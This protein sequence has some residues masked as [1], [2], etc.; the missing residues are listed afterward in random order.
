MSARRHEDAHAVGFLRYCLDEARTSLTRR[1]RVALLSTL[2][3]AAAVFVVAAALGVSTA[4]RDVSARMTQAAELSVYLAREATMAERDAAAQMT[5]A[6]T[7]VAGA[8]VLDPDQATARVTADFPDLAGVIT[9]L[10]EKPF[11]AVIEVRLAPTATETQ[12]EA[13]VARLRGASGVD[14]V[15]YDREVL[16]RVLLTVTTVRRVVTLL[17]TLLA[18]AAFAAVAAVL[19]LGYYA[20]RDEIDV[21]GLVGAPPRAISG[22]FIAEGVLQAAA[23]TAVA[24]VLVRVSIWALWR[25][26]AAAWGRALELPDVPFLTW[27]HTLTLTLV[28]VGAGAIAGWVGSRE[29]PR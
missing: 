5:R 3:L 22:P 6:D 4:L 10:P 23:G 29:I 24:L 21:L 13:L 7:A 28:A 27:Q 19:R 11:G 16:R 26:P 15:V 25:G 2:L 1:W 20:R 12:V 9:A 17:A 18:L 8:D 14:D